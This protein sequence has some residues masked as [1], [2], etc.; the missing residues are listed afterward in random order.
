MDE[1]ELNDHGVVSLASG[2]ASSPCRAVRSL[3]VY[4]PSV[5]K[6]DAADILTDIRTRQLGQFLRFYFFSLLLSARMDTL[7]VDSKAESRH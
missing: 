6:G 4:A 5:E 1:V 7:I 3:A 2:G